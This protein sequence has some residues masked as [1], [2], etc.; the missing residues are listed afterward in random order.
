MEAN[1]DIRMLQVG[2]YPYPLKQRILGDRGH[3]CNENCGRLISSVLHDN[4]KSIMLGHLS[5]ENNLP[6]LAYE[7]VKLE[8]TMSENEYNGNDFPIYVAQRDTLSQELVC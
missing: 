3:L 1:H 6:E 2:R 8:I 4:V 5:K 7:T